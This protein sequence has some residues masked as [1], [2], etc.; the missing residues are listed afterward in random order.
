MFKKMQR[1]ILMLSQEV[2]I[3]L[4]LRM[5]IRTGFTESFCFKSL[6]I[7]ISQETLEDSLVNSLYTMKISIKLIRLK[8]KN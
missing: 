5:R 6:K 8:L 1:T 4:V 7:L 2:L 3:I